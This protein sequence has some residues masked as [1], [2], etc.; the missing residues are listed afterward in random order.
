MVVL[1]TG[2]ARHTRLQHHVSHFR[3]KKTEHENKIKKDKTSN[4]TSKMFMWLFVCGKKR[5][6]EQSFHEAEKKN[7]IIK[8]K[9]LIFPHSCM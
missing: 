2:A 9:I 6:Q 3:I 4:T 8:N 7:H 1:V 5:A